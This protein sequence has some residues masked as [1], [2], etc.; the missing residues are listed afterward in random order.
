MRLNL[1]LLLV[2]ALIG[3]GSE[4]AV[5]PSEPLA[6]LENDA[7]ISAPA[8]NAELRERTLRALGRILRDPASSEYSGVR[9]GFSGSIC[10]TVN[11]G[12]DAVGSRPFVIAPDGTAYLSTLPRINIFDPLD[13]FVDAYLRWCASPS[14]LQAAQDGLANISTPSQSPLA[15][16]GELPTDAPPELAPDSRPTPRLNAPPTTPSGAS[17]EEDTFA[18]AVRRRGR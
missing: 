17:G 13:T 16:A 12:R 15:P 4:P 9:S 2:L 18:N 5:Q 1:E 10:G 14:E 6:P 7:R 11:P 3:C 8:S